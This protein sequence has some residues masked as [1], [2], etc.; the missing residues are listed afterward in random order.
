MRGLFR[1][2]QIV[3]E[4]ARMAGQPRAMPLQ[5]I[6]EV[7]GK[8]MV[9]IV[10]DEAKYYIRTNARSKRGEFSDKYGNTE[11]ELLAYAALDEHMKQKP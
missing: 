7:L 10:D 2:Y 9:E 5:A 1:A 8:T 11:A 4:D 3:V 6:M